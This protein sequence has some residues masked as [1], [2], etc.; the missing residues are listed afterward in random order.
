[1]KRIGLLIATAGI[2]LGLSSCEKKYDSPPIKEIPVGSIKTIQ[3]VKSMY[4]GTDTTF[5]EEMTIYCTVTTDQSTG[6]FYKEAYIK[7]NTGA[8]KLRFTGSTSLSIGDSM[9]VQLNGGTL[10]DYNGMLSIDG[11]DPIRNIVILENN[12]PV[13]PTPVSLDQV[14]G[15]LQSQ[16]IELNGVEFDAAE[17]GTTWADAANK[18]SVNHTLVDCSQNMVLV[19][20]SGYANFAGDVIPNGNGKL[21]GV[22]GVFGSDVQIFIRNPNE[23]D[24]NG[25]RCSGGGGNNCSPLNGINEDFTSFSV[26]AEVNANCWNTGIISGSHRWIIGDNAGDHYASATGSTSGTQEM[27]MTTPII[28]SGGNDVLSF[29]SAQQNMLTSTLSVM[30]STDFDGSN[31]SDATWTNISAT[32]ANSG[33][34]ANIFVPSGNI[35]LST[36]LGANYTGTYAVAFKAS[37]ANNSFS[38]FKIDNVVIS[39]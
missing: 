35:N 34:G 39:Q 24:M 10:T 5:N 4:P 37:M 19:R 20:T 25:T 22:V 12:I 9:R 33:T 31:Y 16:L 1:M 7:D 27:W 6:N 26:G 15:A 18:N 14:T 13:I 28:Q 17:L 3:E 11:L 8:I 30:V 21:I 23:L 32:L 29:S 2:V 36:V 38:M